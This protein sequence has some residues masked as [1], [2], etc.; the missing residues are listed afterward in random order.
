M[1]SFMYLYSY[2]NITLILSDAGNGVGWWSLRIPWNSTHFYRWE[3][4]LLRN[5]W[6]V[7]FRGERNRAEYAI[8]HHPSDFF[9]R[10]SICIIIFFKNRIRNVNINKSCA[11]HSYSISYSYYEYEVLRDRKGRYEVQLRPKWKM[12]SNW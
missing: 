9:A 4:F 8:C 5:F 11:C 3:M 10:L 12:A 6:C 7:A 2:H 1:Y